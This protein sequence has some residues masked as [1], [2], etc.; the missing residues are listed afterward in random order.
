VFKA[1]HCT[2]VAM[3]DVEEA[4]AKGASVRWL[5]SKQDGAENFAMRYF[6]V[7]PGGQ[8]PEHSHDWEHE[9]FILDGKGLAVCNGSERKISRG[10]VIFIPPNVEHC[11]KNST[12]KRLC[13][14]CLIPYRKDRAP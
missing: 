11:I 13:F 12:R 4:G 10:Y 2:E 1:V 5:I 8:T 9:V 3:E 14:L 7:E 6:E